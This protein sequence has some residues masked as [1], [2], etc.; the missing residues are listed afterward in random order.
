VQAPSDELG[1]TRWSQTLAEAICGRPSG[2][3]RLAGVAPNEVVK[4]AA[5]HGVGPLLASR[6]PPGAD[7]RLAES[8][9][10]ESVRAAARDAITDRALRDLTRALDGASVEALVFKGADLAY[11]CYPQ[12]HLR[13]RVDSDILVTPAARSQADAVLHR[14]GYASE[15]QSGG[16]LLMY[17]E[18]FI[19][20]E[21]GRILHT[22]DLHWRVSNPQQFGDV[23]P[24]DELWAASEPRP[25]LDPAARGLTPAHAFALACVHRV[26]HHYDDER[27]IWTHDLHQIAQRMTPVDWK[28]L[29]AWAMTRRV[30]AVCA[31]G[32]ALTTSLFDT[33][34]PEGVE[35]ELATAG[36]REPGTR[37]YTGRDRHMDRILT[38]LALMPS[39]KARARLAR[40]HVLPPARYMRDVYAPGSAL[41]V[42][43]LYVQRAWR[44]ARRWMA[45]G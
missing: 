28:R 24:F 31:R 2:W 34:V 43:I 25:R 40:Q 7:S 15:P 20:R 23:A 41:P 4:A 38:D 32:L 33:V 29:T 13:P 1:L 45:K 19:L 10:A 9:R 12:S 16:D 30:A 44:G 26:A 35:E 22:V 42:A 27:L 37:R 36:T 3:R 14:L 17:Q 5:R 39:W 21:G 8:L 18:P 11:S 6:V